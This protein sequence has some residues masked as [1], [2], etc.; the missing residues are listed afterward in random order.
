MT[1]LFYNHAGALGARK[2]YPRSMSRLLKSRDIK[3]S[4]VSDV[5]GVEAQRLGAILDR[6]FPNGFNCWGVPSGARGLFHRIQPG[7]VFLLIGKVQIAPFPDGAFDYAA[8]IELTWPEPLPATSQQI[9]GEARWPFV[10]FFSASRVSLPWP[11]FLK[12]VNYRSGW[13]PQ[14]RFYRVNPFVY[15]RLPGGDPD[16]YFQHIL[17][18]FP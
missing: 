12:D 10:F 2:H 3:T 4:L 16:G 1:Q 8:K 6:S 15:G 7:D 5:G 13:N 17:K 11:V 9:W 14:G 18:N